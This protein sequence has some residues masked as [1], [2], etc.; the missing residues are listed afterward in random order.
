MV[1][2]AFNT[3][4]WGK[5]RT[6]NGMNLTQ[7]LKKLPLAVINIIRR[8]ADDLLLSNSNDKKGRDALKFIL[9]LTN[10]KSDLEALKKGETLYVP[11]LT[12]T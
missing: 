11:F 4:I 3:S 10:E 1:R 2:L 12:L 6:A 5:A 8:E 9:S 7:R